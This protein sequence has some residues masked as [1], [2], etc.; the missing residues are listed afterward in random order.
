MSGNITFALRTAQA[1]LLVNQQALNTVA[2]NIANVNTEGYSRKVINLEQR[3]V[4]GVGAGVQI[5]EVA[6]KTDEGLLKSLRGELGTLQTVKIQESY[7]DQIQ[8]LFG[9]PGDNTSISH[10]I[11]EFASA[12]E[13][14]SV[15]PNNVLEQQDLVRRATEVTLKIRAMSEKVQ[16]MRT[17]ADKDIGTLVGRTNELITTIATLNDE[18]VRNAAVNHDVSDLRD[19]LDLAL[20][21][22]SE[23][24]DVTYF[25]RDG[26]DAVVFTADGRSIVSDTPAFLTHT[27]VGS[28]SA[29]TTHAAGEITGLFV[30]NAVPANDITTQLTKGKFK[31]LIDLRD[32]SLPGLQSQLDEMAA[33]LRDQMNLIHNRGLSHPGA[34][35]MTGT[36][37]FLAPATST[38]SYSGTQDTRVVLFDQDG[39]QLKNTTIRTLVTNSTTTIDNLASELQTWL[40]N[41]GASGATVSTSDNV[42]DIQLNS[43]SVYLAF[44]D[45]TTSTAGSNHQDATISFDID[46]SDPGQ[47]STH[48]GFSNFFGLNDFFVDGLTDNI[49]ESDVIASTYTFPAYAT[50]E[51][52]DSDGVVGTVV[53]EVN[54][55][56]QDLIDKIGADTTLSAKIKPSLVPDGSGMR[57]RFTH[58]RGLPLEVYRTSGSGTGFSDINVH[59]SDVRTA[60]TIEVRSDII[61][62]PARVSRGAVQWDSNRGVSGEYISSAGDNTLAEAMAE[63]LTASMTFKQAG[64]LS[65]VTL[66]L[67]QYGAAVVATSATTS[68]ANLTTLNYQQSLVDSLMFKSDSFRGVNLDEE[69]SQIIL[70]ET[71]YNASARLLSALRRMIDT[72]EEAIK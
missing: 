65:D 48:T 59:A 4:A 10:V 44:R 11:Q 8:E 41:N 42:F 37:N 64:R 29:T 70:F 49:L 6:R 34:Q 47:A 26:G 17:Q 24:L 54:N 23:N 66:T 53:V 69:M 57:L 32:E 56:L 63:K 38:I 67:A 5:S 45:E 19:K 16:D 72:L 68:A 31:G 15:T 2:N 33:G 27:A 22:L 25:F 1:G 36:R 35:T 12:M 13:A 30:G 43:T 3:V 39:N 40:R 9:A 62:Q 50:Y 71:A 61:T 46:G 55:T 28:I 60:S 20:D 18:I 21:E 14:L 7:L 52:R 51:F 58:E